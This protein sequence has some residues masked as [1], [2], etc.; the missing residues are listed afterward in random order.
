MSFPYSYLP[1]PTT[2]RPFTFPFQGGFPHIVPN[3]EQVRLNI[4]SKDA[5][6]MIYCDIPKNL[7]QFSSIFR[8][9]ALYQNNVQKDILGAQPQPPLPFTSEDKSALYLR[10]M[11]KNGSSITK[12]NLFPNN[13]L[14]DPGI[15]EDRKF[16]GQGV[17]QAHSNFD[18]DIPS[19]QKKMQV[20]DLSQNQNLPLKTYTVSDSYNPIQT[21]LQRSKDRPIQE[22]QNEEK[23]GLSLSEAKQKKKKKVQKLGQKRDSKLSIKD[24]VKYKAEHNTIATINS[25]AL[26]FF[27]FKANQKR[28]KKK[29]T[30][31]W[32]Y[33]QNTLK[34]TRANKRNTYAF[35]KK[36]ID[37]SKVFKGFQI[38]FKR[39]FTI[40]SI[41]KSTCKKEYKPYLL[42]QYQEIMRDP[43][44]FESFVLSKI[45]ELRK[46]NIKL[47]SLQNSTV[48]KP[49][50]PQQGQAKSDSQDT[51]LFQPN[52]RFSSATQFDQNQS[53][54][55]I[56]PDDFFDF[57]QT[58]KAKPN[59]N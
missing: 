22:G 34:K 56:D 13:Q 12:A 55:W 45:E 50:F 21:I 47:Y 41:L 48:E 28:A 23:K 3:Q 8:E 20:S 43:K 7:S 49:P 44:K 57:N 27:N 31:F 35:W 29:Y 15:V 17:T 37:D 52:N 18:N 42:K 5:S 1:L 10:I 9:E 26:D 36:C 39:F 2:L 6:K 46:R 32:N 16:D 58:P 19:M 4:N 40:S 53:F 54:P 33:C 24:T 11:E 25:G 59:D 38:Y 14:G 30:R 51:P